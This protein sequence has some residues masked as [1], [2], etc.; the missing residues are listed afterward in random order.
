MRERRE[1]APLE[2]PS[3]APRE[4]CSSEAERGT[5]AED[6]VEATEPKDEDEEP[7]VA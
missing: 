6:I 2:T 3:A 4:P 1:M 5:D 7:E